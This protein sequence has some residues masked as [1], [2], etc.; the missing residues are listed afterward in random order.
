[1]KLHALAS[2]LLVIVA[3]TLVALA[4]LVEDAHAEEVT[5]PP[6]PVRVDAIRVEGLVRTH[7]SVVRRE[8]GF[9]EGDVITREQ[10]DLAFTRLWNTT[11]FA[12]VEGDVVV[13]EGRSVVVIRV[14]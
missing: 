5:T 2:H 14:E 8:L 3:L 11:I 9:A 6:F 12:R 4:L 10:Y 7:P 13:E 1:M